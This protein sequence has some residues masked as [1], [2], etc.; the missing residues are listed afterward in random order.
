MGLDT[1][2]VELCAL[3]AEIWRNIHFPVMASLICI[4][5]ICGTFCQ[6]FNIANRF[7]WYISN[8]ETSTRNLFPGGARYPLLPIRLCVEAGD[9]DGKSCF[10][11]F[12]MMPETALDSCYTLTRHWLELSDSYFHSYILILLIVTLFTLPYINVHPLKVVGCDSEVNYC[13]I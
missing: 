12:L 8:L 7:L 1:L 6:L 13:L 5:M 11:N 9:F 10:F 4:K 3:L 2:I